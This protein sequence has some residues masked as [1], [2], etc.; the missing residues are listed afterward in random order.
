MLSF[1]GAHPFPD[2]FFPF[3]DYAGV[4][5]IVSIYIG[6]LL[7][8]WFTNHIIALAQNADQ[9]PSHA[10]HLKHLPCYFFLLLFLYF[11]IG[12]FLTLYSLSTRYDFDYSASKYMISFIGVIPGGLITALPIF[13]FCP[14]P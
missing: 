6:L 12:L 3:T 11:S 10:K 5:L 1:V 13:S 2:V 7:K 8:K 14:I 9:Q 4:L